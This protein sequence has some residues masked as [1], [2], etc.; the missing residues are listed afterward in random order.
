[1]NTKVYMLLDVAEEQHAYAVQALQN[2]EGVLAVDTLEGHPNM[3]V[4]IEA[5]DRQQL[6]E[7][8]MAI[9]RSLEYV[10]T[11]LRFLMTRGENLVTRS[12]GIK[13]LQTYIRQ[14]LN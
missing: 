7:L 4:I 10:I 8:I 11:D 3:I 1:M 6:A 9:L 14:M 12:F 5:V 13:N 2:A